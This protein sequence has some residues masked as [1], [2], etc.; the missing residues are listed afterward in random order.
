MANMI[1]VCRLLLFRIDNIMIAKSSEFRP[2]CW[3][4]KSLLRELFVLDGK[5]SN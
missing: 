3:L 4:K 1:F 2:H 5:S